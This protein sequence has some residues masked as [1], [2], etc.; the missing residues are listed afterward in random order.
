M[1]DTGPAAIGENATEMLVPATGRC[2][3][4]VNWLLPEVVDALG[5]AGGGRPRGRLGGRLAERVPGL[6][7]DPFRLRGGVARWRPCRTNAMPGRFS[8]VCGVAGF[9]WIGTAVK[10]PKAMG[11]PHTSLAA[12]YCLMCIF[13]PP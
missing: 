11:V 13:W 3:E 12:E 5:F 2:A 1:R 6:A 10:S 4:L 9:R 7:T 8:T